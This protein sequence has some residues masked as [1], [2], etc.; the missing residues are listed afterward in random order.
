MAKVQILPELDLTPFKPWLCSKFIHKRA[1]LLETAVKTNQW[2]KYRNS[3]DTKL[4]P[5][6]GW[7]VQQ[8]DCHALA[9]RLRQEIQKLMGIDDASMELVPEEPSLLLL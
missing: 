5:V 9:A 1:S 8:F 3:L 6:A 2:T 4:S 7:V